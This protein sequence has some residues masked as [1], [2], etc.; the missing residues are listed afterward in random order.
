MQINLG[1]LG[2]G[3]GAGFVGSGL[4]VATGH[5]LGADDEKIERSFVHAGLGL[6]I[7]GLAIG[8]LTRNPVWH[9]GSLMFGMG[10]SMALI[11]ATGLLTDGD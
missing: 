3:A 6:T 11:G 2:L 5:A 8:M 9:A 10:A 7:G 1:M 4:L